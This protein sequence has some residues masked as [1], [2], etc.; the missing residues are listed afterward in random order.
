MK[1]DNICLK[2]KQVVDRYY[3]LYGERSCQH[4]F[5]NN[6][7]LKNKYDDM[8]CDEDQV[9]HIYRAGISDDKYRRYLFPMCDRQDKKRIKE[10]V[11]RIIL[12]AHSYGKKVEF[13]T[14]TKECKNILVELFEDK[15]EVVD[16]REYYEYIFETERI[17][18]LQGKHFQAKRNIIHKLEKEY[19]NKILVKLI[20]RE[21]VD[22]IK[23]LYKKWISN[24]ELEDEKLFENEKKEFQLAI[25]NFESLNIIGIMIF[26]DGNLVGFNFGTRINDDTYDGMIQKGD[27]HYNGIYELLN[28]ESAKLWINEFK[29][30]N[31]EEDLGVEGLRQAKML[32]KPDILLEKYI[33]TEK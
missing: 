23:Q 20:T 22:T 6:Y 19:E 32:Y 27:S 17:A 5:A 26:I 29:F 11:D 31:F 7:C 2:L 4:S 8:Y 25:D 14:I 1:F 13:K 9:L 12:D 28:R 15:F 33:A 3:F 30:L 21:D 10:A 24:N 16:S 18:A